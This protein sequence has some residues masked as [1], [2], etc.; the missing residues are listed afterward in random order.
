MFESLFWKKWVAIWEG[1][2]KLLMAGREYLCSTSSFPR[3]HYKLP[4]MLSWPDGIVISYF[5]GN[6]IKWIS[7]LSLSNIDK[8][9]QAISGIIMYPC[10]Q[11]I[12]RRISVNKSWS[13]LE[14]LFS[15]FSRND[16]WPIRQDCIF[17]VAKGLENLSLTGL[18]GWI[19]CALLAELQLKVCGSF[20]ILL[21]APWCSAKQEAPIAFKDGSSLEWALWG[22]EQEERLALC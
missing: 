7:Y 1:I 9:I 14:T 6:S 13:C 16:Y 20:F 15:F 19:Q 11:I 22:A 18:V 4:L 3:S 8:I 21:Q 2:W 17:Y 5:N 10:R 12:Q